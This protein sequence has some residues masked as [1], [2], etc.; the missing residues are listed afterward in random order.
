MLI[1][2]NRREIVRFIDFDTISICNENFAIFGM[3]RLYPFTN[4]NEFI[5][6]YQDISGHRLNRYTIIRTLDLFKK[7]LNFRICANNFALSNMIKRH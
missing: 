4:T 3:L 5:E 1:S 7:T 2:D 6:Y